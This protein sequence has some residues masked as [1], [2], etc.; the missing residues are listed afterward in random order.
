MP[1]LPAPG[2]AKREELE[3]CALGIV[4]NP[5]VVR[6]ES[7]DGA[8]AAPDIVPDVGFEFMTEIYLA[9]GMLVADS[10]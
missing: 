3:F 8:K 6:A 5:V 2:N 4:R 7:S 9:E 1:R 10:V